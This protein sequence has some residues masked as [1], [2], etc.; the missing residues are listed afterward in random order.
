MYQ[1]LGFYMV[2]VVL[3]ALCVFSAKNET[4]RVE[5]TTNFDLKKIRL[6]SE[7]CPFK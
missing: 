2:V 3:S 1:H 5:K 6:G 4:K 7:Y